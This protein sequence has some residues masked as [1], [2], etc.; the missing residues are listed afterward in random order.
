MLNNLRK[1]SKISVSQKCI[2]ME[3][4]HA[5]IHSSVD[6]HIVT[7]SL[8]KKDIYSSRINKNFTFLEG[9]P[10]K[11]LST[12]CFN[13]FS[14]PYHQYFGNVAFSLF[15]CGKIDNSKAISSTLW[16]QKISCSIRGIPFS[17]YFLYQRHQS[18]KFWNKKHMSV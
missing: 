11:W 12:Y 9:T 3:S 2:S 16:G 5:Q 7:V 1:N 6:S 15:I 4:F 13:G 8:N 14:K 18:M 10:S 17:Y